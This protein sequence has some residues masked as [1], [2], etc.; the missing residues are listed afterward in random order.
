M[1]NKVVRAK[2]IAAAAFL[3]AALVTPQAMAQNAIKAPNEK[4]IGQAKAE[5]VPSLIVLNAD[6]ATLEGNTL[7][8]KGVA[9]NSII[10][11]DRP[12]RSAGHA[13]TTH[14]IEEWAEGSDS[15]AKDPPNATVS[16]FSK[17]ADDVQDAVVV[18][19]NPKLDGTTLTFTVDVL[20]SNI[21][22]ADGPA[23][24][25]IDIIGMPFT[26]LSFAGVARRTAFRGAFYAGAAAA[27]AAPYYYPPRPLCGYYPYPP[28]Y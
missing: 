18:L 8:L 2:T 6:G 25:F 17:N 1:S 15:F 14:L 27:A 4:T 21:A 20:E 23:S 13:L 24:V 12:V 26:P 7:T 16:V 11:A 22:A 28:C 3:V 9:T 10:F 19:K 5:V